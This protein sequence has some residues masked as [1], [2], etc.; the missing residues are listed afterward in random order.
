MIRDY[1]AASAQH[2]A[3]RT[4][5][6]AE[7]A[8]SRRRNQTWAAR[9]ARGR[10]FRRKI[11]A[12]ARATFV[13][14]LSERSFHGRLRIDHAS[15]RL[16]I[17]VQPDATARGRGGREASALSGGEKSYSTICLLLSL[18]D[19]VGAPIRCL[20]EFDVYM[21]SVNRDISMKLLVRAARHAIG[22]Q[23]I[24]I[25]PQA[26]VVDSAP[27]VRIHR[28]RD[29]ERNNLAQSR[30]AFGQESAEA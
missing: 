24:F 12:R 18:W 7:E 3:A 30:L 8:R 15:R 2:E 1:E 23:F 9:R 10:T 27:D 28:L 16:D 26:G 22:R 4:Q 11:C 14:V 17:S 29:P 20:D 13:H 25:S 6:R 5:R 21:D 19:A